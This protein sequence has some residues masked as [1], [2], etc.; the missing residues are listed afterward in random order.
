MTTVMAPPK[1]TKK[2]LTC[3]RCE[4]WGPLFAATVT[5]RVMDPMKDES[6]FACPSCSVTLD[7]EEELRLREWDVSPCKCG[8]ELSLEDEESALLVLPESAPL[9]EKEEVTQRSWFHATYNQN[10]LEEV[11]ES[12]VYVHVGS[13]DSA[14]ERAATLYFKKNFRKPGQFFLWEVTVKQETVIADDVM[15]DDSDW[16]Y[17]VTSCTEK[18]LGGDAQRYLNKFES[19]G[20]ISMLIDPRLIEVVKVT[21]ILEE[22]CEPFQPV[23]H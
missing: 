18:H 21:E 13:R 10:W 23:S 14:L 15:R 9:L 12:A 4:T 7:K 11:S 5:P 3:L 6:V 8:H 16:Y 2:P 1:A 17:K 22:D 19:P 20:S